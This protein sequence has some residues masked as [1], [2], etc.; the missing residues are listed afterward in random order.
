MNVRSM[1]YSS[2]PAILIISVVFASFII[3]LFIRNGLDFN[4]LSLSVDEV[5]LMSEAS[6]MSMMLYILLKR[7][8][9][10]LLVLILMKIL[11]PDFVYNSII[12]I[13]SGM[14]GILLTVQTYYDGITGVFLLILYIF[15]HYIVYVIL[16]NYIYEHY[17]G[18][19]GEI[20]KLKFLMV[21]VM[22]LMIG[23]LCEGF[24]SR[25]FL[26]KFYQYMVIH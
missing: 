12:I 23:V 17:V 26:D 18:G 10:V 21:T 24:F 20:G 16:I 1:Q 9:H 25:F 3:N 19:L 11:K 6:Y 8:K 4:Y 13:L 15:P 14:L 7:L 5:K 2:K 22:L